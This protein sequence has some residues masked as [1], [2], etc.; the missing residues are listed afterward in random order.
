MSDLHRVIDG[1]ASRQ[2]AALQYLPQGFAD[3]QFGDEIGR[4][5]EDSELVDREDVGMVESRSG[6]SFLLKTAKTVG[7]R[8]T[9]DGRTLIATSRFSTGS[10]AR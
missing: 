9:N 4:A 8:E 5:V 7:S 6:L 10:R 1:F 3:E 2:R